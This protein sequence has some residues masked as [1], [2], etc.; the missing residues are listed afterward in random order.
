MLDIWVVHSESSWWTLIILSDIYIKFK[1]L[2]G[3]EEE[4]VWL[5]L[6]SIKVEKNQQAKNWF[7]KK[8]I[9]Q[10]KRFKLVK[11]RND[12]RILRPTL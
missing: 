2:N 11:I 10:E 6:Q 9:D 3:E 4:M 1:T 12:I 8:K 7:L 5:N